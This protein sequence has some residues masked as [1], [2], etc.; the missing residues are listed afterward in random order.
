MS[1]NLL[2]GLPDLQRA[3]SPLGAVENALTFFER[4]QLLSG[5]WG[6]ESGGPMTFCAGI[7][8][9]WYVTETAIPDHVATELQAYLATRVNSQDGGW[10]FIR[11]VRA[12]FAAPPLIT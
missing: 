9:A 1:L 7:V 5:H 3:M 11:L 10:D 4:L 2:Q 6:C 12:T 8:I